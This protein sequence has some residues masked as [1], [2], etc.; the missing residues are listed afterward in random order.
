MVVNT[1]KNKGTIQ[2]H[3]HMGKQKEGEKRK[4]STVSGQGKILG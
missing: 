3:K 1:D 2:A 4:P